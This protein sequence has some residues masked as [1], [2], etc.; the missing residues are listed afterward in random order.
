LRVSDDGAGFSSD[1][2][3]KGKK[4]MGLRIMQ[5]RTGMIG[6]TLAFE[7][8]AD[9]GVIVVCSAPNPAS[10]ASGKKANAR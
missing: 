3:A 5:S 8:N 10:S 9:G 4:G 7:R 6:G 2:G 1:S